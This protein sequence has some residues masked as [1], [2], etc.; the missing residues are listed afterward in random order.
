MAAIVVPFRGSGGKSR[1]V[2]G[3]DAARDRILEAMLQDVLEA[4]AGVGR[5]VVAD[6]AG[7]QGPAVAAE[8]ARLPEEPVLV[9][10]ADLPC[11]TRR[12]VRAL[13]AAVP[14]GGIALVEAR[15]GTTNALALSSPRQF[16]SLYGPGSAA[17]FR[18]HAARLGVECVTAE[19]PNLVDDV[20]TAAD[21][22][23]LGP[24]AGRHTR[25][26]LASIRTEAP[27]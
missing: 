21:L 8:L 5:I 13:L 12:D 17:R 4:A 11:V 27:A 14:P 9:V 23:R 19:L 7:G 16:A 3:S 24:R 15:D 1:L 2:L 18:R 10:N 6:G 25:S 22:D 26:A 20:D